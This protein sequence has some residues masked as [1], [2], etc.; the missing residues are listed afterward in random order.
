MFAEPRNITDLNECVFYHSHAFPDGEKVEGS[1]DLRAGI[2]DYIGR[3]DLKGKRVLE[4]GPAS[5]GVSFAMEQRGAEVVSIELPPDGKWDLIPYADLDQSA[6][7]ETFRQHL[8][9][10]RNG[11]WYAHR[12]YNSNNKV[13]YRHVYD[14]DASIGEYDIAVFGLVLLHLRDPFLAMQRVLDRVTEKAVIVQWCK[15]KKYRMLRRIYEK[16]SHTRANP[17]FLPNY[18]THMPADT[19]WELPESTIEEFAG[20]NGFTKPVV[21][22]H[23]QGYK[24]SAAGTASLYTMVLSR[25]AGTTGTV[26]S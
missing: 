13:I 12:K 5:G 26:S 8:E 1:F 6:K 4:I 21:N 2:D 9:K 11:Y 7:V 16:L 15:T 22:Y 18:R 19:W 17:T 10:L 24:K 23:Q 14:I 25:T 3:L 20:V